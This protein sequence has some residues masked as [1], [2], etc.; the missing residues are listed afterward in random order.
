MPKVRRASSTS[1]RSLE[2]QLQKNPLLD[3]SLLS[4]GLSY[5]E[6]ITRLDEKEMRL[7]SLDRLYTGGDVQWLRRIYS[8]QE[9]TTSRC[10]VALSDNEGTTTYVVLLEQQGI[11]QIRIRYLWGEDEQHEND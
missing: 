4:F 5:N 1:S 11:D 8:T 7:G 6:F 3:C 9:E 10:I 2:L